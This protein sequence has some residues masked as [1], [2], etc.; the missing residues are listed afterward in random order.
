M[1]PTI[2]PS[3]HVLRGRGVGGEEATQRANSGYTKPS[4]ASNEQQYSWRNHDSPSPRFSFARKSSV[5]PALFAAEISMRFQSSPPLAQ[6]SQKKP[7]LPYG[8]DR[9]I[10]RPFD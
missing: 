9:Q 7:R 6:A 1:P 10:I 3:P 8:V 2:L 5:M 4:S